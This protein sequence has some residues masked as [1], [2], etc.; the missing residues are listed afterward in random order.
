VNARGRWA[1]GEAYRTD[2]LQP[3][4][5]PERRIRRAP[6]HLCAPHFYSD[7]DATGGGRRTTTRRAGGAPRLP[8]SLSLPHRVAWERTWTDGWID[9]WEPRVDGPLHDRRLQIV[10]AISLSQARWRAAS[11]CYDKEGR[12]DGREWGGH[13]SAEVVTASAARAVPP[14]CLFGQGHV[15]CRVVLV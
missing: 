15:L 1:T 6:N 4:G 7:R 11:S 5:S 2:R 8:R 14:W 3:M 9:G 13:G 10:P 12:R